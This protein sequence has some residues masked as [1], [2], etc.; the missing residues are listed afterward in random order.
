MEK[1]GRHEI[2]AYS[3]DALA[4]LRSS[5][6]RQAWQREAELVRQGKGTWDWSVEQQAELL[7]KKTVSGFEG[8]HMLSVND[9]PE[10][11][12]NPDNIQLLP[13][14]AH[15][16]GVHEADPRSVNPNGR[17]DVRSGKVIPSPDGEIPKQEIIELTDK[18][19]ASQAAYH[20][21]TPEM[22]QSGARRREEYRA[23]RALHLGQ[24]HEDSGPKTET[25][26]ENSMA[27]KYDWENQ[28]TAPV[29]GREKAKTLGGS[30]S[31][32]LAAD[33]R[34]VPMS[35]EDFYQY[36]DYFN[37]DEVMNRPYECKSTM[38]SLLRNMGTSLENE[39]EEGY[40]STRDVFL[41]YDA[42]YRSNENEQLADPYNAQNGEMNAQEQ[43]TA[44]ETM[45]AEEPTEWEEPE[46]AQ[47]QAEEPAE[48]EEPEEAE[49][50]A[51]EPEEWEE[52]E[53]A[54]AQAEEPAEWEE[55]EEAEAQAEE[56]AE[57]EEP[58]EAEAQAEE[59]AQNTTNEEG[60]GESSASP[61]PETDG[62]VA[63]DED[64]GQSEDM[65]NDISM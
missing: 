63:A 5:A 49:A 11:A 48:W 56:P 60:L 36:Y 20:D 8:S 19:D 39:D 32:T 1:N 34:D 2:N 3:K 30:E 52:P 13:S 22:E 16:D 38:G 47:A 10:Y 37:S 44:S 29:L 31:E 40:A 43:E 33:L 25:P 6:V 21:A 28:R 41:E 42:L 27:S 15:F 51:E 14:I 59:P 18:Y 35:S 64:Q 46:E 50:Q 45:Q 17:F 23:S 53:E 26:E 57:W 4:S 24:N 54:E 12:G 9:Y 55:P 61:A 65:E 62:E 7:S 58:E